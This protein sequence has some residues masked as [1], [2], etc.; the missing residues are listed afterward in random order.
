[1]NK[2]THGYNGVLLKVDLSSGTVEKAVIDPDHLAKFVGGRGLGV[3]LLWDQLRSKPGADPLGPDNPLLFMPGPFCGFPAP[4]SSRTCVVTKSPRTA[5]RQSPYEHASTLSYA[6]MGGF[7]G[8]ELRFA[9]YDG[10]MITGRAEA[11]VYLHIDD[12][13]VEIRDARAYWGMKTDEFDKV[14]LEDLGD[15]RFRTCYIGPGGENQVAYA[16]IINTAARAAGRGGTGCVM[17]NKK[18]KAIAVR[19][20]GQ[21]EVADHKLFLTALD[22]AREKFQ[23]PEVYGHWRAAGTT[24]AL[25]Y[26]SGHGIQAVKNFREGTFTE[27]ASIG[28]EASRKN[29]IRSFAC[30][31][32]PLACKK[33]GKTTD[34]PFAGLVHD[35]PEYETGT[36]LGANLMISD[37]PG[38]M[39]AIYL[40]DDYGLDII[41]LGNTIG[42]LMEA[43]DRDLIDR[44]FLDGIDLEWGSVPATLEMIHKIAARDGIGDLASRGVS[45]LADRIGQGSHEFAMHVKGHELAAHNCHANPPRAL[46]YATAHRGACHL[47]GTSI[48]EQNMIALADSIGVCLF[49]LGGYGR[50]GALIGKLMS[51][52]TGI[53]GEQLFEAGERIYNLEQLFNC[54]EGFSRADDMVPDRF[55]EEPLTVG[56]KKGAVL[57]RE[58]F[59]SMM[60][61]FYAAR[62]WD[63]VTARPNPAKLEAL[64]LAG[65]EYRI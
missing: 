21:P 34:S 58:Q 12:A 32:C 62:D 5:P 24:A 10:L 38:L 8:P 29:W 47:N 42:F 1:M 52:I 3:K 40:G 60:D 36:M 23:D 30:Y 46:C 14:F 41:S 63:P 61:E 17:G 51:G 16:C 4:S 27:A 26:L 25:E 6:N 59:K 35:G 13:A 57:T 28:A 11:P 44:E 56:D 45:A 9:G 20:T 22:E 15:S 19:G 55:F 54:R 7:F 53:S 39:K 18:L 50:D 65:D 49:A 43:Y 64:G 2:K 33:S 37:L 31:C 48:G